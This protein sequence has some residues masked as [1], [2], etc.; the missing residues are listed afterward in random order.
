MKQILALS[1]VI[2]LF[3]CAYSST[4]QGPQ[5]NILGPAETA[6]K[7]A[8]AAGTYTLDRA[9]ASLTFRVNHMGLSRYTA[10]FTGLDAELT[11][12]PKDPARSRVTATVDP[13]SLETDYPNP[14]PDFDKELQGPA[15]LD[16]AQFTA[17][18]FTST[19]VETTGP[20]TARVTGDLSL[21]GI[22]QPVV[23]DVTFNGSQAGHP[24]DPAKVRIGFSAKGT[25][26]RSLFWISYG[27]PA[28]G[29]TMGVG[30]TVEFMIESEFIQPKARS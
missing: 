13:R 10:R 19:K 1:T 28:P 7:T 2:A 11:L 30:D 29:T 24:M 4:G 5:I 25:L 23:M 26:K 16:A 15:W 20:Y 6:G 12:D 9:H 21:H 17:I 14:A 3:G 27:I 18:R 8:V 22:T